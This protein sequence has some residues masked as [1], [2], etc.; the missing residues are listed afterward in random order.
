[1]DNKKR[2]DLQ[3]LI[4]III[5]ICFISIF[6]FEKRENKNISNNTINNNVIPSIDSSKFEKVQVVRIVDGDT[7]VVNINGENKKVRFIGIN[8]PENTTK[9]EELGKEATEFTTNYLE[10]KFIFLEKDVS[11]TD[12]YDRLLRY[13][14]LDIPEVLSKEEISTKMFNAIL[15][16]EGYAQV[17]T[18][19]PDI[20]YTNNFLELEKEAKTN[21]VGLW[22][23]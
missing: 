17:A 10:G 22:A 1:M 16:K 2:K 3:I 8:T 19:P 7:I 23:K 11:N 4:G 13:I 12:K 9:V 21:N 5:I 14:W 6:S 15:L 18:Y 20:K